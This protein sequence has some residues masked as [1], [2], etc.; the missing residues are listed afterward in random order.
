MAWVEK[1]R[2]KLLSD[3]AFQ[4]EVTSALKSAV[5]KKTLP[6]ML[7]YGP[8]G[9]GKTSTI[10]AVAREIY[11]PRLMKMRVLEL[12]ASDE[13][14]IGVIR[15]KVKQFAQ[16]AVG[17]GSSDGGAPFKII[18]LDEADSMTA[19]AQA[20]L[21]RTMEHFTRVTRFCL[22]CNYVSRII[23]PLASRCAKF[24]FK[25][26]SRESMLTRLRTVGIAESVRCADSGFDALLA[27]SEGDMR[28]AITFLQSASQWASLTEEEVTSAHVHHVAG[29]LPVDFTCGLWTSATSQNF[30]LLQ[31]AV[32]AV[33]CE[34]Y[35]MHSVFERLHDECIAATVPSSGGTRSAGPAAALQIAEL[36]KANICLKLAYAEK[37][38]EDGA[39]EELQLLSVMS[40]A[41]QAL[42]S[43]SAAFAAY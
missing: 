16:V 32:F 20:A 15:L 14:G 31:D 21:R 23:D 39:D 1:H 8:P 18:I 41:M 10:L 12:N 17:A 29:R 24:R 42:A 11:G 9:T 35:S 36:C 13:R 7:F 33:R 19:Q 30:Q 4:T 40:F 34:G 5:E 22:I 3:I 28:R 25:P 2:P 38:L 27:T 37:C 26:L 43:K 6:H